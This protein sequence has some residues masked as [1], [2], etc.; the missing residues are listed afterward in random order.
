MMSVRVDGGLDPQVC[1]IV[2][3]N[4]LLVN[5]RASV[6]V[7]SALAQYRTYT[8]LVQS[9]LSGTVTTIVLLINLFIVVAFRQHIGMGVVLKQ[10]QDGRVTM[11]VR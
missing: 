9:R 3:C 5:R 7:A 1:M 4:L 10:H 6:T 2:I 8:V 11:E